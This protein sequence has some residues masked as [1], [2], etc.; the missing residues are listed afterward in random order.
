MEKFNAIDTDLLALQIRRNLMRAIAAVG[1]GHVG[2]SLSI[3]EVLAVLY[4]AE[5]KYDPKNPNW[6]GRDW[7]TL[8]KGHCGPGLYGALAAVGFYPPEL[9]D[10]MNAP[11]TLLPSHADRLRTPGIDTTTG[12]LGQGLS[13]A[14]GIALGHKMDKKPNNVYAICG[15]GECQEGQIWEA[16]MFA[17]HWKLDNLI[18]F[19]DNN[20]QQADGW[21]ADICDMGDFC[22]KFASF[23]WHAQEVDGHD[24]T[25]IYDAIQNAKAHKGG[26][27]VIVLNTDKGRGVSK[28]SGLYG[29]HNAPVSKE[30]MEQFTKEFDA[31]E[32][33]LLA[34]KEGK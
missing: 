21:S 17:T 14:C 6:E 30:D 7:L 28:Y 11:G 19:V 9:L 10:T 22:S 33:E 24:V 13:V 20:K 12:S 3:A 25:A 34:A 8:S 16:A 23:G 1:N 26:P 4:G 31:R 18:A 5:M 2:G 27:S 15:D 29:F 32:A